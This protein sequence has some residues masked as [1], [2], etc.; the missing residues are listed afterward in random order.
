MVARLDGRANRDN[1]PWEGRMANGNKHMIDP[2]LG[3]DGVLAVLFRVADGGGV[4]A[5]GQEMCER[6]PQLGAYAE[7]DAHR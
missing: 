1:V 4:A 7:T 6:R 3:G 2:D 5:I